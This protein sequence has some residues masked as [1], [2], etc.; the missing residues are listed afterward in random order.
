[1][2]A[3][4]SVSP[5]VDVVVRG[6]QLLHSARTQGRCRIR[7]HRFGKGS[8][9]IC[10]TPKAVVRYL[11]FLPICKLLTS[12]LFSNESGTGIFTQGIISFAFMP[13]EFFSPRGPEIIEAAKEKYTQKMATSP[14]W[15]RDQYSILL[16]RLERSAPGCELI[17]FP[18][19]LSIGTCSAFNIHQSS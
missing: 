18:G 12:S 15:L 14:L 7:Y 16:Q 9:G 19:F 4:A 3:E 11:S 10:Q 2:S 17:F 8:R 5:A 1:M 13:I 6:V